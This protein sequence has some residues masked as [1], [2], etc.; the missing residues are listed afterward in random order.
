MK[1]I[2]KLIKTICN[3]FAVL[4]ISFVFFT[5]LGGMKIFEKKAPVITE[6]SGIVVPQMDYHLEEEISCTLDNAHEAAYQY[7]LDEWI[8]EVLSRANDDFLDEYFNFINVKKREL[9]SLYHSL[10]HFIQDSAKTSEEAA[11][12]EL[13][14]EISRKVIM[15]EISQERIKNITDNAIDV[16]LKTFDSELSKLQE[17]HDIPTPDWNRYISSVC[18]ITLS[19][20][21]KK[22]P[23]AFK[24]M[25]VSGTTLTGMAATPIIE[26]IAR[27][28]SI[29]ISEQKAAKLGIKIAEK[30][31]VNTSAK[32]IG[33]GA[34]SFAKSIP[35]IGWGVTA[36]ICIWDIADYSKTAREGKIFVR[37]ALEEYLNEIK[38]ELLG[39][40]EDS[41]MGSITEWE[42]NLKRNIAQR[43]NY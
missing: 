38:I 22:Y 15:P 43:K 41:I 7:E 27:K 19:A 37:T 3:T 17:I 35:Y 20:D 9:T 28:V 32:T 34:G 30:T 13:E 33:K 16:F 29:K 39:P 12:E 14:S 5:S 42:N 36:A 21:N 10:V 6:S 1:K 18:G 25:M 8:E 11:C 4:A 31:A 26:N 24:A 2:F 40:T 23:I